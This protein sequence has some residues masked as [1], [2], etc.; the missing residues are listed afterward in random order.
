MEVGN[1][2]LGSCTGRLNVVVEAFGFPKASEIL[3]TCFFFL[4]GAVNWEEAVEM[5]FLYK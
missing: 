1:M 2:S 3:D 5:E 4:V